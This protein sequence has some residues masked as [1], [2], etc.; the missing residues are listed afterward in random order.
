MHQFKELSV[1]QKAMVLA[2]DVYAATEGFPDAEKFGLTSK[3]R[4]SAVSISSN[5]AEGSGRKSNKEFKQFLNI[6]YGSGSEL[7]SQLL[8]AK[9]LGFMKNED[10]E[11]LSGKITKIQ[12]MIY[13]L[14]NSLK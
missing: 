8:I 11:L 12:K 9:N 1:W 3:I 13:S 4:R 6:A 2:T 10:Y 5:I 7:E 14:S